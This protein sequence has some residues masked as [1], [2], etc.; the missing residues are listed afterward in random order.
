MKKKLIIKK[1]KNDSPIKEEKHNIQR[2]DLSKQNI[3]H[4][5]WCQKK[6]SMKL[7]KKEKIDTS[8]EHTNGGKNINNEEYSYR[9]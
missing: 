3:I 1:K 4:K 7:A 8:Q 6:Q 2:Y 9:N 5:E